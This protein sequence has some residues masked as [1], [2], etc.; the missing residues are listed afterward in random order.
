MDFD[1]FQ[2]DIL[3]NGWRVF[4]AEVYENG[5]LTH[6]FGDT[7]QTR[8]PIYSITKSVTSLAVGIARTRGRSAWRPISCAACPAGRRKK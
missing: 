4:G 3:E 6:A 8:H 1:A 2:R 5:R 7:N